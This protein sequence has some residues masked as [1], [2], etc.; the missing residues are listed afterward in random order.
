MVVLGLGGS[1]SL[2]VFLEPVES[3][4]LTKM[5]MLVT[6]ILSMINK[7]FFTYKVRITY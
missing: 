7:L 2:R 6:S 4:T 3:I 1:I 5:R